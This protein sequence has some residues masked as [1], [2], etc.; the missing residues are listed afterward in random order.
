MAKTPL[1]HAGHHVIN[2]W[3]SL[4]VLGALAV[5]M[6]LT[7]AASYWHMPVVAANILA[8][9]IACTKATLVMLFFMGLRWASNLTRLWAV[10]G[11][12]TFSL[13]F[14]ILFDYNTR[15][16]EVAPSWDGR[17][18]PAMPRVVDPKAAHENQPAKVDQGFLPRNQN[19]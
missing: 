17:P 8:M 2:T 16:N 7:I 15:S 10:A 14:I 5:L 1:Q 19:D 4:M 12:V 3:T 6:V 9:A 11:F 13:M 18:E